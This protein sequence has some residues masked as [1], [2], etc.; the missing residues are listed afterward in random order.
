MEN[1]KQTAVEWLVKQLVELDYDLTLIPNHIKHAKKMEKQQIIEAY[2][3]MRC[4]GNFENGEQ[5]YIK[6]YGGEK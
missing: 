1:K 6:E 5:Y 2:D 3:Q 4:V